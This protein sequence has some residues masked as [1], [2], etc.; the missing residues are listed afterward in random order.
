MSVMRRFQPFGCTRLMGS[1]RPTPVVRQCCEQR[2][3]PPCRGRAEVP[4]NGA[5]RRYFACD[6]YEPDAFAD[7]S[8]Q[9]RGEMTLRRTLLAAA[10]ALLAVRA[11]AARDRSF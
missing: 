1:N 4:V 5:D 3:G 9:N 6:D 8:C 10:S 2:V 11:A 7:V